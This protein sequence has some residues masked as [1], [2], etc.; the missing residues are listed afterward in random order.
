VARGKIHNEPA[1]MA[2]TVSLGQLRPQTLDAFHAYVCTL[3]KLYCCS[4]KC[5]YEQ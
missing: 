5:N 1:A 4:R 3:E 2:Q